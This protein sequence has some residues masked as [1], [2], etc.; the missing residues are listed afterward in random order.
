MKKILVLLTVLIKCTELAV[1]QPINLGVSVGANVCFTSYYDLQIDPQKTFTTVEPTVGFTMAFMPFKS[2]KLS[3]ETGISFVQFANAFKV[4][5][6]PF[7]PYKEGFPKVKQKYNGANVPIC[8]GY[9][10]AVG[11]KWNLH[12]SLGI[13]LLLIPRASFY[14]YRHEKIDKNINNIDYTLDYEFFFRSINKLNLCLESN[15]GVEYAL[16]RK[17]SLESS[18]NFQQGIRPILGSILK[19]RVINNDTHYELIGDSYVTSKGDAVGMSMLITY[20]FGRETNKMLAKHR[21]GRG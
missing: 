9:N 11:E 10:F 6:A 19:Y 16:D 18:I 17:I 5:D 21:H 13:G 7:F 12:T 8:L 4:E 14:E 20:K 2:K 1:S 15:F 3:L